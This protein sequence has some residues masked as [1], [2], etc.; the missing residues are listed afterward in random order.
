MIRR[1]LWFS[2]HLMSDAQKQDLEKIF[3]CDIDI[4]Q[5][6]KT[7]KHAYEL[8]DDMED[9]DIVAVVM[10]L[11]LQQQ[12]L[13]VIGDKPMLISKNH[14]IL[15]TDGNFKFIHAGWER[16]RKIEIV[17]DVLRSYEPS[18]DSFR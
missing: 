14:R 18:K 9:C 2:R 17:S 13:N 3:N 4:K 16:I 12:M 15:E 8:K 7:I 6:N 1:V 11:N 10:P 5:V